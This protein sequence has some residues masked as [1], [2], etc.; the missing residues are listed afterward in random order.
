MTKVVNQ[1]FSVAKWSP[2]NADIID[3][4]GVMLFPAADRFEIL[5]SGISRLCA[6]KVKTQLESFGFAKE[7]V[8]KMTR[9]KTKQLLQ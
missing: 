7:I 3:E 5:P 9:P 2:P 8:A 6:D 1:N 4:D